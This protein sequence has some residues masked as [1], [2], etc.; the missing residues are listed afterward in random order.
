M[1][2]SI[3]LTTEAASNPNAMTISTVNRFDPRSRLEMTF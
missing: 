2:R 3:R 1:L